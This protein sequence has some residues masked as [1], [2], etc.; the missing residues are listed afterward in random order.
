MK[1]FSLNWFFLLSF[2]CLLLFP[3]GSMAQKMQQ[4]IVTETRNS[5]FIEQYLRKKVFAS[6][7]QYEMQL[8]KCE[9]RMEQTN[10]PVLSKQTL[11]A[12]KFN[13]KELYSGLFYLSEKNKIRCFS[14]ERG[15]F[16]FDYMQYKY[17]LDHNDIDIS[18][19]VFPMMQS[20]VLQTRF[21]GVL[22][23]TKFIEYGLQLTTPESIEMEIT[24]LEMTSAKRAYLEGAVGEKMFP[25]L[26]VYQKYH[27]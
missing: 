9:T 1:T 22:S 18:S 7:E 24:Y 11:E 23:F 3:A 25:A 15:T 21:E 20:N 13:T 26:A 16:V 14:L 4:K 19:T 12:L 6:M 2:A 8:Q 17:F 10:P 27:Q 5:H